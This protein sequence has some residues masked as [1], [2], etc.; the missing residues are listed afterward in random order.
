MALSPSKEIQV[1]RKWVMHIQTAH[2]CWAK[3]PNIV[4]CYMLRPFAHPVARCLVLLG[5]VAQS[6]KLLATCTDATILNNAA[7]VC[8]GIYGLVNSKCAY[9]PCICRAFQCH[10]FFFEKLKMPFVIAG[11]IVQKTT[12]RLTKVCKY[13]T[14]GKHQIAFSSK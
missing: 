1:R 11:R 3:T 8:T 5:V 12:V 4:G 9:L 7:P 10:F 2:D 14:P 6:L 13:P